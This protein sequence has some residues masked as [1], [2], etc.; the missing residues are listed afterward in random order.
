MFFLPSDL[1]CLRS[2]RSKY[3]ASTINY[4]FFAHFNLKIKIK[5]RRKTTNFFMILVVFR[6][7]AAAAVFGGADIDDDDDDDDDGDDAEKEGYN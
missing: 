5:E 4:L 2:S 6:C 7:C 1:L 3:N